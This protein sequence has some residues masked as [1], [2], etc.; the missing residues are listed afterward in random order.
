MLNIGDEVFLSSS[1]SEVKESMNT[2]NRKWDDK[3]RS[4]LGKE[5]NVHSIV[6]ENVIAVKSP[7]KTQEI[8]HFNKSVLH[9]S[10]ELIIN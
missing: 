7:D 5:W 10:G 2:V 8:F 3:M 1:E 9:R 4:M 6:D